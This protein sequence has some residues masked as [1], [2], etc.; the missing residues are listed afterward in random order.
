MDKNLKSWDNNPKEDNLEDGVFLLE[1]LEDVLLDDDD[2]VEMPPPSTAMF[3]MSKTLATA[4]G[5]SSS[6]LPRLST[7]AST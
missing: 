1:H 7:F 6:V 3:P 2:H 5:V 4:L